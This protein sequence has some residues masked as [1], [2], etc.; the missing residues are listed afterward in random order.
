M[1]TPNLDQLRLDYK[2]ATDDWVLAIREEEALATEDHS[3]V[4]M[5]RWDA[6]LIKE[7]SLMIKAKHARDHYKDGLRKVNFGF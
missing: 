5:A 2:K 1:D 6:A 7:Q 3:E 4:A